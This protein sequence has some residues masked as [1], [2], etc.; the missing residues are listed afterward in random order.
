VEILRLREALD[1]RQLE[2][3]ASADVELVMENGRLF[4]YTGTLRFSEV[5][6]D[7]S[8]G[9]V[10]LRA[11]VPNPNHK[12]LPGM[13]VH[14]RLK[15]GRKEQ[16]ILVPQ[17]AVQGDATG[18]PSVWVIN[19]AS[20]VDRRTIKTERTVGNM[21]LVSEGLQS[22]DSVITEGLQQLRHGMSVEPV[23]AS[24]VH[25]LLEFKV[26]ALGH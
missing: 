7:E 24:N 20:T 21:W 25:P 6:V 11:I 8:T 18:E 4:E 1:T 2:G 3:E 17:Q 10:T 26:A 5:S 15:Q 22:G 14:A 13:F 16:A 23:P 9:S 12:L 19:D